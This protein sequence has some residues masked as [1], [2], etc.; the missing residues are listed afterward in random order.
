MIAHK[1][2]LTVV[3]EGVES[4]EQIEKLKICDCDIIQGYHISKPLTEEKA[5]EFIKSV[6]EKNLSNINGNR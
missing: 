3:A 2:G 4:E 1:I 5:S 6:E